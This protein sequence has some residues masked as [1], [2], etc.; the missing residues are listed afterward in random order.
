MYT[1]RPSPQISFVRVIESCIS[2]IC[3]KTIIYLN[4]TALLFDDCKCVAV[5]STVEQT[6]AELKKTIKV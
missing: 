2:P 4:K 5:N 1:T 3:S 6:F